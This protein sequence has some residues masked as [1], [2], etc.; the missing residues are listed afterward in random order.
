MEASLFSY[1]LKSEGTWAILFCF[2]FLYVLR[3]LNMRYKDQQ[4]ELKEFRTKLEE[5]IKLIQANQQFITST[6]Q[7]ILE[8]EVKRRKKD[9]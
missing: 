7:L 8:K 5:D 9:V 4:E 2:M 1:F 3:V 6:W